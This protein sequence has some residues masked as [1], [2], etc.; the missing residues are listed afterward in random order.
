MDRYA[1]KDRASIDVML[2]PWDALAMA[3]RMKRLEKAEVDL[4]MHV[5]MVN[6]LKRKLFMVSTRF[7][8]SDVSALRT[9][10]QWPGCSTSSPSATT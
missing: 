10:L 1:A 3:V 4:A 9:L 8:R 7:I 5:A 2:A 6:G